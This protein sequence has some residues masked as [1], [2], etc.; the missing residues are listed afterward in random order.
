M[1]VRILLLVGAVPAVDVVYARLEDW[2]P[3]PP[4]QSLLLSIAWETALYALTASLVAIL[5]VMLFGRFAYSA[6]AVI[7]LP[8]I[9]R[10]WPW[11]PV[12]HDVPW[13]PTHWIISFYEL[14]SFM[15]FVALATYSTLRSRRFLSYH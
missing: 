2:I 15:M 1:S 8:I 12:E 14:F 7:A 4:H 3:F 5:S 10:L 6:A 9:W 11:N 13:P